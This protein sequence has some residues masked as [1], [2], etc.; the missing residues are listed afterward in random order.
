[1]KR[2]ILIG[3]PNVGKS[4]VFTRLTGV[5]ATTSNYPG[6]TVS[7]T[8]GLTRIHGEEFE[9]VDT[10]GAY[11]LEYTNE[12]EKVA[13]DLVD[14]GDIVVNVIDA[15][16]LE[17]NLLLTMQLLERGCPLLVCLNMWDDAQ[18]KGIHIDVEALA[19]YLRVPVVPT[20]GISGKGIHQLAEDISAFSERLDAHGQ[21]PRRH[22]HT[23]SQKW[24]DIGEII[25]SV[26]NLEHRHH[27]FLEWLQ[28][29]SIHPG[30]GL[31][32]AGIVLLSA[33]FG[34]RFLGES[35]IAYAMDPLFERGYRPLVSQISGWLDGWPLV[36]HILIGK[37]V[38]GNIDY[39]QSMGMLTT[40]LYV[41][42]AMVL[43][44]IMSFY[45]ALSLMEDVGYLPRLGVLLDAVMHKIGLHGFSVIPILLGFGCNVP[46]ILA[47]RSLE[48][49][50]QRFIACTLISI[51]IP[52]V[53]LQAM[54]MKLV[55]AYGLG[56]VA[57]VYLFL[58]MVVIVL[59]VFMRL[60]VRGFLP[61]LILEIPPYRMPSVRV[62]LHKLYFR[63]RGF[64]S[65][66][67]PLILAGIAVI[68]ILDYF[69]IFD[70]IAALT[71][72]VVTTI[73]GLP[74]EAILPIVMG[75]LRKDIA[76]GLLVPLDLSLAQI[77]TATVL[78]SLTFPCI[79]TFAVLFTE[80]GWRDTLKSISVMLVTSVVFGGLARV[81]FGVI[82]G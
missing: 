48:T 7:Y 47:T 63:S 8:A 11:S 14:S 54:I 50:R 69:K 32:F 29:V 71:A 64:L 77:M 17:R 67:I 59:G 13:V 21:F 79:A 43:P 23:R 26:Q 16:N 52:C 36:H 72:P 3:N 19:S 22:E 81:L 76:A 74:R 44:Y 68:N 12:A 51:G 62:T 31:V 9:V 66:A 75:F 25:D 37:L 38:N 53:S 57:M 35:I 55:G 6:T 27:T 1:M 70:R 56:F 4:A 18:H 41:P 30:S 34:I 58:M 65:E 40:G 45:L 20:V 42:F 49:R 80:L 15:T 61:E 78:L 10:P 46:G 5:H 24:A 39:L 2:L 82:T 73:W 33:F 60:I 28:D